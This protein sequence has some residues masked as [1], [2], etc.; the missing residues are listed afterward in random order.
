MPLSPVRSDSPGHAAGGVGSGVNP[1]GAAIFPA[2]VRKEEGIS[3]KSE[4]IF[5]TLR[6]VFDLPVE[7]GFA[8]GPEGFRGPFLQA[9]GLG[10]FSH[11]HA[12]EVAEL[13]QL[14]D[15]GVFLF[16]LIQG[17]MDCEEFVRGRVHND[18][19]FCDFE[20][21]FRY[22]RPALLTVL[23]PGM[24][25]ENAP[26]GLGGRS[27]KVIAILPAGP[28][29]ALQSEPGLMN[30]RSGLQSVTSAFTRHLAVGES[31]QFLVDGGKEFIRRGLTGLHAAEN[32]GYVIQ[33]NRRITARRGPVN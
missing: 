12:D 26:H 7:P 9:H 6:R 29:G 8:V 30:E 33:V 20:V 31:P 22:A 14:G 27:E 13:H 24:V 1:P 10:G 15:L 23:L 5:S 11:G 28:G 3:A 32:S 25:D 17:I 18:R 2:R 19:G 21:D 4:S 16:Q